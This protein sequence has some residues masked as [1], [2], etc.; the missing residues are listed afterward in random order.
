MHAS[1]QTIFIASDLD[2]DGKANSA[3]IRAAMKRCFPS[4]I[5]SQNE[6]SLIEQALDINKNGF[7]EQHEFI[8]RLQ[9][10]KNSNHDETQIKNIAS[11]KEKSE[12]RKVPGRP[13][14]RP[15]QPVEIQPKPKNIAPQS[16]N[17][18]KIV[19]P[20]IDEYENYDEDYQDVQPQPR[21]NPIVRRDAEVKSNPKV[22]ASDPRSQSK[23]IQP[24]IRE[25]PRPAAP[26][27]RYSQKASVPEQRMQQKLTQPSV[28]EYE[29]YGD[30]YEEQP[31]QPRSNPI[32][33]RDAEVRPQP[34]N[35]IP[36]PRN[37]PKDPQPAYDE[38]DKRP[39]PKNQPKMAVAQVDEYGNYVD[40]YEDHN[41][42]P[43]ANPRLAKEDSKFENKPRNEA[44]NI[45]IARDE[46]PIGRNQQKDVT[47]S[48]I[49][50]NDIESTPYRSGP[51]VEPL[52]P[53][54]KPKISEP[55]TI[56][57][58]RFNQNNQQTQLQDAMLKL[59]K[60]INGE[61]DKRRILTSR[62][63]FG[64]MD[65]DNDGKITEIEFKKCL[66]K[67]P[68]EITE[69]QKTLLLDE[70]DIN[71]D[72]IID[73]EEFTDF[74]NVFIQK[75]ERKPSENLSV[76]G[77]KNAKE[78]KG[79]DKNLNDFPEGSIDQAMYKLKLYIKSNAANVT[80]IESTFQRL[81]ED[82]SGAL[83]ET[84]FNLALER[85]RLGL[86]PKQKEQLR[87]LAD[88]NKDGEMNYEE[89][90]SLIYD[91]ESQVQP[92]VEE[93][94]IE[95]TPA[96]KRPAPSEVPQNTSNPIAEINSYQIVPETDY[97]RKQNTRCTTILNSE[98]SAL[99]RCVE[100][101]SKLKKDKFKDPDFGPEQIN[102]GAY[103]LY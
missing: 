49:E 16:R 30:E 61:N 19:Q 77:K 20:Q 39:L 85:L 58:A 62:E 95:I 99:K 76:R 48:S 103:C 4:T 53:N 59:G 91:Y 13:M 38:Y 96:A 84:E 17:V 3:E 100:L 79:L 44:K 67:L 35:V 72:G 97:F 9:D 82:N 93:K 26:E 36:D 69:T 101:L 43:R 41:I 46:R 27:Q 86:T 80:S 73:Y 83:N 94:K 33:R 6:L 2:Q 70:A 34:K 64:L 40:E 1:P 5:L 8:K 75:S 45:Q 52:R 78:I 90:I 42:Q 14:Q 92:K 22:V 32:V 37:Q 66:N 10:A 55:S 98:V 65:Y 81:D 89:F 18:Q 102:G 15:N 7:I 31:P 47:I 51:A 25:Q 63:I 11:A 68:I 57:T 54:P 71:R 50:Q 28:D 23:L 56:P 21:D 88:T 24:E 74:I 12:D 87:K 29:N 60:Y